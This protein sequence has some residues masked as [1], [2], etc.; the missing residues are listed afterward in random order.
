MAISEKTAKILWGR[1][2]ATCSFPGC[3]RNLVI[4]ATETDPNA[5]IGEMAHIIAHSPSGPRG[6]QAFRGGDRDGVD[7]LILLCT[8]HH[9]L[10]DQQRNTYTPDRLYQIKEQHERWVRE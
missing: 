3:G 2:G 5:L 6:A 7:N 8:V 4:E 1:A 10:I 9:T